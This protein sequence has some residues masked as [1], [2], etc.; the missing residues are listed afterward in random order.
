[1]PEF[2][3]RDLVAIRVSYKA[4]NSNKD[5]VICSAYLPHDEGVP[6]Q[7]LHRLV[8]HCQNKGLPLV[9]GCD[10][11]AHNVSLWGSTDDNNRGVDLELFLTATHLDVLNR[12]NVGTFHNHQREEVIDITLCTSSFST[13]IFDWR[14]DLEESMSDHRHILFQIRAEAPTPTYYRSAKKTDWAL[15]RSRLA[16]LFA[17]FRVDS[18]PS[19]SEAE[20]NR[21]VDLL[22][23]AMTQAYEE[24]CPLRRVRS[25]R[26]VP[27]WS[28]ELTQLRFASRQAYKVWWRSRLESDF[29][30]YKAAK[31]CYNKALKKAKR[32]EWRSSL[33]GMDDH[34]SLA[35]VHR[36]LKEG[37]RT[38]LGMLQT[39]PGVY[40]DTTDEV[41]EHMLSTHFPGCVLEEGRFLGPS[42][43]Q[44]SAEDIRTADKAVSRDR[45]AWAIRSFKPYKSPGEDGILPRLLQEGLDIILDSLVDIYRTCLANG[46]IPTAWQGVRV[47]FLPKLG[48]DSYADAKSYRP[49]SLMSFL[50]K[51]LERL[52][53][54]FL[55]DG[56]LQD[57]PL[58]D[59]MHAYRE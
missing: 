37:H 7:E 23:K 55:R 20:V 30:Q 41:L 16:E 10:A 48:K 12:G 33:T 50:L 56:V 11:N 59:S 4:G 8:N 19:R 18:L 42:F 51:G 34:P 3:F 43:F 25:K 1:M 31:F 49:I 14:V 39:S 27:W 22:H 13:E 9:V 45:V 46:F 28:D 38:Q 15:Y 40:T 29:D 54:R 35:R 17:E 32:D 44:A 53:D 26:S 2:C 6:T 47:V 52:V 58:H 5:V 36:N 24:A 57:A 21:K